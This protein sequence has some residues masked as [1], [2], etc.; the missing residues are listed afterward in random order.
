[1]PTIITRR[2]FLGFAAKLG[3][4]SAILGGSRSAAAAAEQPGGGAMPYRRLGR[5]GAQ[6]SLIGLGGYHIGQPSDPRDG[7][8]I[9]RA[10][11]DNGINFMD[12]SWDYNGGESEIR[13][14]EAL[15]GGYRNKVFLMTKI[16]GRTKST[17][18]W[19]LDESLK[20]LQT[21]HLDLLQI[22]EVIRESDPDR[23]FGPD[24][25]IEALV[26]ARKAGKI[27]FIGFTGHKSP[28][29]HLKT[30]RLADEHGFTFDTVQMPLNVMDAHYD[31]FEK[32]VL[33]VALRHDMGVIAMKAFGDNFILQSG[34][35]TPIDA[36]HYT[37]NLPISTL[38]TGCDY[39]RWLDQA[40]DAA[41]TFRPMTTAQVNAILAKTEA[42]ARNGKYEYY[43]TRDTFDGTSRNLKWLG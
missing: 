27:R 30:I 12:N 25:A 20:R 41:H 8:A 19:Q 23:F 21:D 2:R 15:R 5:T 16:D 28:A 36:L 26:A 3:A 32:N 29:I 18:A 39:M 42:A 11:V 35:V 13:M 34:T 14:G 38:V 43:K 1:M 6:V 22:H 17:A 7:I 33:P 24:G 37:M 31:S 40:L 4:L 10:A 9:V